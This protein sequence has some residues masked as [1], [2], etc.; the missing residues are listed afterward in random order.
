MKTLLTSIVAAS[1]LLLAACESFKIDQAG[2]LRGAENALAILE[3]NGQVKASDAATVRLA[4][5]L[6]N[7][8][9]IDAATLQAALAA[10]AKTNPEYAMYA[11]IIT[12]FMSQAE[13]TVEVPV[14]TETP[15]LR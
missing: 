12:G 4:L 8:G 9:K 3:A 11:A 2:L 14:V 13:P 5:S 15:P 6:A 10:L 7:G 1:M